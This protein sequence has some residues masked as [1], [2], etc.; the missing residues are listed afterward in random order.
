MPAASAA[1]ITAIKLARR[2]AHSVTLFI[3]PPKFLII[4]YGRRARDE[5][6]QDFICVLQSALV[7][8]GQA[9]GAMMIRP[10]GSVLLSTG[11]KLTTASTKRRSEEHTSELQSLMRISYAVFCLKKKTKQRTHIHIN[12]TTRTIPTYTP[13]EAIH[14]RDLYIT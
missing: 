2:F 11:R 1:I 13:S 12:T 4:W 3:T 5:N 10:C 6:P 14:R 7:S 9:R 8:V